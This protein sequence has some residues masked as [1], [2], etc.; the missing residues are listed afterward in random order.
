MSRSSVYKLMV[1]LA[2]LCLTAGANSLFGQ[3][4]TTLPYQQTFDGVTPPTIPAG[5]QTLITPTG[6]D[7]T[8]ETET[9][10][11]QSPPNCVR[12]YG[13]Y[14]GGATLHLIAP[15]L[16]DSIPIQRVRVKMWLKAIGTYQVQLGV[17]SNPTDPTSFTLV[18]GISCT[19]IWTLY[20]R[21]LTTY[22][23]TGRYIAIRV[24]TMSIGS[25]I[26]LDDFSL[27]RIWA[28]DL[29]AVALDRD[30]NQIPQVGSPINFAVLVQNLGYQLQ[31]SYQVSLHNA[32]TNVMLTSGMGYNLPAGQSSLTHMAWTPTQAGT[33]DVY[34]KVLLPG[35][36]DPSNNQ[37]S[38]LQ[39]EVMPVTYFYVT[40]G[41]NS[42]LAR[43]PID[44]YWKNSLFE[45]IY[46]NTEFQGVT[47]MIDR[48]SF[49]NNFSDSDLINKPTRIWLGYTPLGNLQQGWI[50]STQLTS[51]FDGTVD[52]PYGQN[53]I[54]IQLT[55]PF[56]IDPNQ[57]LVMMVQRPFDNSYY[58]MGNQFY[59]QT[60][61]VNRA[62]KAYSDTQ[63]FDP[64]NPPATSTLSGQFPKTTFH[65]LPSFSGQVSGTVTGIAGL[66]VANVTVTL[67]NGTNITMTDNNGYYQF[68]NLVPG[69]YLIDFNV[70]GYSPLNQSFELTANQQLQINVSLNPL[71]TVTVSGTVMG[72]NTGAPVAGATVLLSGYADY[73]AITDNLG[74]F[75]IPGVYAAMAYDC[76]ISAPGYTSWS[77]PIALGYTNFNIGVITLG[78]FA[79]PPF[80]PQAELIDG[81]NAVSV[82]WQ[83]PQPPVRELEGYLIWRV[84]EGQEQNPGTWTLLTDDTV[85]GFQFTDS[86]WVS[87]PNGSYRWALKSVYTGD[88]YS[89]PV[90]TNIIQNT[91]VNG[92]LAGSVRQVTTAPIVGATVSA[93]G[94][95]GTTNHAGIY[96]F[97]VPIG[98]HSVTASAPGY[99]SETVDNVSVAAGQVV[100]LHFV[101][102]VD[103]SPADDPSVP[104]QTA[105]QGNFPNPF[106]PSTRVAFTLAEPGRVRISV[107]N[108]K[109]QLVRLLTDADLPAGPHQHDF[110][111]RDANGKPISSGVYI[112][113]MQAGERVF[114]SRMLLMK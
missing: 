22:T 83:A 40:V 5:W 81:G 63:V 69:T 3:N 62:R 86:A 50:P 18:T 60:G 52:Y 32:A 8:I 31:S 24:P 87:I 61:T 55:T 46:Y 85:Q 114:S 89:E 75:S 29:A 54:T 110:D 42:E 10:D 34:A 4:I 82:T 47:G 67:N 49:Y 33:I 59:A 94:S 17:M 37:S 11:A 12:F 23:G 95:Q 98:I 25:N 64:A 91:V 92:F 113:R 80:D 7:A 13:G 30:Y 79:Y 26:R 43:V 58:N 53:L 51:V 100:S 96:N 41:N 28:N 66:P 15:A 35:D 16:E 71:P 48:I 65:I 14:D 76:V 111:G 107:H 73:D 106:N 27:Q 20:S 90:F 103:T 78:E 57:N 38:N 72:S 84:P 19:S 21:V 102:E 112:L 68:N 109:G 1:M 44:V 108:L 70:V 36:G 93:A 74:Q 105:L 88:V 9:G 45:M 56:L 2:L 77:G 6:S 104:A 39:V 97:I 101:L 99:I